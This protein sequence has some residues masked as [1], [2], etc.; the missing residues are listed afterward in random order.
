LSDREFG[1]LCRS[2]LSPN[3][4]LIS[5]LKEASLPKSADWNSLNGSVSKELPKLEGAAGWG[6]GR[7]R[8]AL[9][10]WMF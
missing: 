6:F 3:W 2:K 4:A 5:S 9:W 1:N 7:V 8:G 10:L